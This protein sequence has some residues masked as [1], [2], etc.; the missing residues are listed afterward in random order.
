MHQLFVRFP[1]TPRTV[2]TYFPD[3]QPNVLTRATD[4]LSQA[5]KPNDS[6]RDVHRAF[7]ASFPAPI[8]KLVATRET[9]QAD[10]IKPVGEFLS[11]L[12]TKYNQLMHAASSRQYPFL[13]EEFLYI[14]KLP[15]PVLQSILFTLCRRTMGI[16]DD[17]YGKKMDVL[18]AE[19]QRTYNSDM[20]NT[21]LEWLSDLGADLEK[22]KHFFATHYRTWMAQARS[23]GAQQ[24]H[25]QQ[26]LQQHGQVQ[27]Q[28]PVSPIPAPSFQ[29]IGTGNGPPQLHISQ[30]LPPDAPRRLSL[31]YGV[32]PIPSPTLP[33]PISPDQAQQSR[34][35]LQQQLQQQQPQQHTNH[36][37]SPLQRS[38]QQEQQIQMPHLAQMHEQHQMYLFQLQQLPDRINQ[39]HLQRRRQQQQQQQQQQQ[40]QMLHRQ[41]WY[42]MQQQ[43]EPMS[44]NTRQQQ[45]QRQQQLQQQQQLQEPQRAVP[46][47][48][49]PSLGEFTLP[50][51]RSPPSI[52][53]V[54]APLAG[55][56][57]AQ[58]PPWPLAQV[59]PLGP[60]V[61]PSMT[62]QGRDASLPLAPTSPHHPSML[63]HAVHPSTMRASDP[64]LPPKGVFI[65]RPEYANSPNEHKAVLMSLH[66]A[67]VRSPKRLIG[68]GKTPSETSFFYQAVKSLPTPP[69]F[70]S[71]PNRL[72]NLTFEVTADQF[73][74]VCPVST[75]DSGSAK[76]ATHFDNCLRWRVRCC[77][78]K[79]K[80]EC[81]TEDEWITLDNT[82]PENIFMSINGRSLA[83]RRKTHN[84]KDLPTELTE[85]IQPGLNSLEVGICSPAA[86]KD[87]GFFYVAVDQVETLSHEAILS[88]VNKHG[89]TPAADTL[90]IIK[91]R[92]EGGGS[93]DGITFEASD[94][95]IDL[96]D[97]FAQTIFTI[98]ARGK[99]CT[100]LECFDLETW[101]KSRHQ[102]TPLTKCAHYAELNCGCSRRTEPSNPDKWKCPICDKDARP[103]SLRIDDFLVG[104]R[105]QLAPEC[106]LKAKSLQVAADGSWKVVVDED[107]DF[108]DSD[109]EDV[110]PLVKR[111]NTASSTTAGKR[112]PPD[113]IELSD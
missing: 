29:S 10:L 27:W 41:Q 6:M 101:L 15:S 54:P 18:F 75:P 82:W 104:V 33:V 55:S 30:A 65:S 32:P 89:R 16:L 47:M 49:P 48:Q 26:E 36:Q 7:F 106:R 76:I 34:H 94:L 8:E 46:L 2:R 4:I 14:L 111:Q 100:H 103:Y 1:E 11:K 59:H 57:P 17:P 60:G 38:Y 63:Q 110:K 109:D 64:L 70:I 87:Q 67:H 51:L 44:Q 88:L 83:C 80:R 73:A 85:H 105:D 20:D 95:S 3:L 61:Q 81:I 31:G 86:R 24:L 5:L 62:R 12:G 66:Q 112:P 98:P 13:M 77:R 79:S 68:H 19:D 90:Q 52:G 71:I 43:Q 53:T 78:T 99:N 50:S 102:L 93:D 22:R 23:H 96:A 39:Q 25:P 21:G 9:M 58:A 69:T 91:Q 92:L 37:A 35:Q 107:G 113:I 72:F 28:V 108:P 84:G 40:H 45:Q 74:V 42:M 97:P 56:G